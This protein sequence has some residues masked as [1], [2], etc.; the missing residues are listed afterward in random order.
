MQK[1]SLHT[2]KPA[3]PAPPYDGAGT[4][5]VPGNADG[6]VDLFYV[7]AFFGCVTGPGGGVP[8]DCDTFDFDGDDDVDFVDSGQLLLVFTGSL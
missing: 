6:N 4:P 5:V 2:G 1:P 7:A 8:Q 3:C